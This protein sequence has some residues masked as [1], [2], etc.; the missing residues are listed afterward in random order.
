MTKQKRA[1][2]AG[3]ILLA[4][5]LA[6]SA[7]FGHPGFGRPGMMMRRPGLFQQLQLTDEQREQI[8]TIF[9]GARET[10]QPLAQQVR[11]KHAAL[12]DVARAQPFD[13]STVRV[14]AEEI[15]ALQAQLMVQRAQIRNQVLAV[16][17]DEQKARL[18]DLRAERLQQFRE[19]R[20]QHFGKAE[21]S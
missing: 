5:L 1:V 12:R 2:I 4:T 17:T 6:G 20:K 13:E 10:M 19:W 18:R 14:G 9:S 11:Q 3:A 21:Q 15:A 8:K 16:L 7:V